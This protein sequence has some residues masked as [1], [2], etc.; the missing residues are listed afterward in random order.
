MSRV[1]VAIHSRLTEASAQH[2]KSKQTGSLPIGRSKKP[3]LW[4]SATSVDIS[5]L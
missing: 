1:A 3:R 4:T 5:G 2:S